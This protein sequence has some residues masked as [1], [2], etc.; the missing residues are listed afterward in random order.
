MSERVKLRMS[1]MTYS[2]LPVVIVVF[3]EPGFGPL[4]G[5]V[6]DVCVFLVD[7]GYG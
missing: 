3:G 6:V 1:E 5:V 7:H 4:D 2:C